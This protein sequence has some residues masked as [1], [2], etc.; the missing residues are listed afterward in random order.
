M[1]F[2]SFRKQQY[3]WN[4]TAMKFGMTAIANG[5]VWYNASP[6][7]PSHGTVGWD[8]V[9]LVCIPNICFHHGQHGMGLYSV[10]PKSQ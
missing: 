1:L 9:V 3:T 10:N 5:T 6:F 2:F 8:N 4:R 7:I